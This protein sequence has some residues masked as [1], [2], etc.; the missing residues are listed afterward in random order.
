MAMPVTW[1]CRTRA[2]D[3][4]I[5]LRKLFVEPAVSGIH[6]AADARST[7]GPSLRH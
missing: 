2:E 1:D 5:P 3:P 7:T 6:V 4:D